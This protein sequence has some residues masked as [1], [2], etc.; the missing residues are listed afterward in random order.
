MCQ[1]AT[2]QRERAEQAERREQIAG[3]LY[4]AANAHYWAYEDG[5]FD[6]SDPSRDQTKEL[7]V[8]DALAVAMGKW[9]DSPAL[10]AAP[11]RADMEGTKS[12]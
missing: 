10:L 2:E 12:E 3:E 7:L 6:E 11:D 5:V 4:S 1:E 9:V 8:H